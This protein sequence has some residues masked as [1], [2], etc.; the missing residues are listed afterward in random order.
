MI[1]PESDDAAPLAILRPARPGDAVE[2]AG[3]LAELGYPASPEAIARRISACA[4]LSG[5]TIFV[6]SVDDHPVGVV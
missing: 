4:D 5:T 1:P 3:L 2:L 6:A